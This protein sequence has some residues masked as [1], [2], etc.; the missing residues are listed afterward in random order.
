MS[1]YDTADHSTV[2]DIADDDV[3]EE[4]TQSTQPRFPFLW[5]NVRKGF[6]HRCQMLG[7]ILATRMLEKDS[8]SDARCS[9]SVWPEDEVEHNQD[10]PSSGE[11][12]EKDSTSDSRCSASIWPKGEVEHNQDYPS[13][14]KMLEKDST[15]DARC[16]ASIWPEGEVE[17]SAS[18][19]FTNDIENDDGHATTTTMQMTMH[20]A[21]L[22]N[23]DY[24]SS[25]KM[26]EKDSTPDA[27]CLASIW[28]P[29]EVEHRTNSV[30]PT[31]I[32][33][34]PVQCK[35]RIMPQMEDA[36]HQSGHQMKWSTMT[37][38]MMMAMPPPH[39]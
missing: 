6:N 14:G 29:G 4:T 26:L 12:L 17:H 13:S 39:T 2:C 5:C 7:I 28:P 22:P 9:A 37:T 15:S 21:C 25:S 38:R 1:L 18:R 33:P 32:T 23:Q 30:H 34:P 3:M 36:W 24:P 27:R 11:M 16:L 20:S 35:K 8:N 31:K 19:C 10:Y